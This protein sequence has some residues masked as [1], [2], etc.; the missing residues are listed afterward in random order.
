MPI[1]QSSCD[2]AA[3]FAA[4][5]LFLRTYFCHARCGLNLREYPVASLRSRFVIEVSGQDREAQATALAQKSKVYWVASRI[6]KRPQQRVL[7]ARSTASA[8]ARAS[9]SW[10]LTDM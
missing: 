3:M 2:R 5:A 8:E 10:E 1:D 9:W 6:G 4:K 7:P